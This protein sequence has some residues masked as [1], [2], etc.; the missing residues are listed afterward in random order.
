MKGCRVGCRI[1]RIT[2]RPCFVGVG[3]VGSTKKQLWL[4][5][6][7]ILRSGNPGI[8]SWRTG[9]SSRGF[10]WTLRHP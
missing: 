3:A 4:R 10:R 8:Q 9:G 1:A 6:K 5:G 7:S 2:P